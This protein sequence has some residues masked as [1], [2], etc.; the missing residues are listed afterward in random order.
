VTI[1]ALHQDNKVV[2]VFSN[3]EVKIFEVN[4]HGGMS[5]DLVDP[6]HLNECFSTNASIK[7][8]NAKIGFATL[9]G[10]RKMLGVAYELTDTQL[11]VSV[12]NFAHI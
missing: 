6:R 5:L 2:V 3:G 9:S 12:W 7:V 8:T 11:N 1:R 10:Q 4:E